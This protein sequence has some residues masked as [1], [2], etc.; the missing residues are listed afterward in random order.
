M[1]VG[2]RLPAAQSIRGAEGNRVEDPGSAPR[3]PFAS[4]SQRA[5]PSSVAN[6]RCP[7]ASSRIAW[8]VVCSRPFCSAQ[9][10][11]SI[12]DIPA[13]ILCPDQQ[14]PVSSR[15]QSGQHIA[16]KPVRDCEVGDLSVVQPRESRKGCHP[17]VAVRIARQCPHQV[18]AQPILLRTK[19][20][21]LPLDFT[22]PKD[23]ASW[24]QCASPRRVPIQRNRSLS[25]KS[26]Q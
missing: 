4:Q 21:M 23:P 16:R 12:P 14:R 17:Q 9:K 8:M 11:L 2:R 5:I 18:T 24:L 1:A 6:Q 13:M 7:S 22:G 25:T 20:S 26:D 15:Q 10:L 3:P 19:F